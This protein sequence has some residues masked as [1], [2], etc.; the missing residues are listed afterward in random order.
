MEGGA[1]EEEWPP[2]PGARPT[3]AE[4]VEEEPEM[5][6]R[7]ARATGRI[8]GTKVEQMALGTE[9]E[10]ATALEGAQEARALEDTFGER[11]LEAAGSGSRFRGAGTYFVILFYILLL[12]N[13]ANSSWLDDASEPRFGPKSNNMNTVQQGRGEQPN[14]GSDQA[15]EP[16]KLL[17]C[18]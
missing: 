11:A 17:E 1:K 15:S 12:C 2:T 6:R 9:A 8:R 10:T 4:Q 7:R 14:S 5:E 3:V 16:C 18:T 13:G